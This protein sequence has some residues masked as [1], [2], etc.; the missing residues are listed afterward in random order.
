MYIRECDTIL[1]RFLTDVFLFPVR[2]CLKLFWM[3]MPI[4]LIA[5]GLILLFRYPYVMLGFTIGFLISPIILRSIG[6]YQLDVNN[7]LD[8]IRLKQQEL[9]I[10]F[11]IILVPLFPAGLGLRERIHVQHLHIDCNRIPWYFH[12]MKKGRSMARKTNRGMKLR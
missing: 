7:A 6:I 4:L 11:W 5:S 10:E 1:M 12:D 3:L 8:A 9:E 2:L